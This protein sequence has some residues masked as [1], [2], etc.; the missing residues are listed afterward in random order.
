MQGTRTRTFWR[1]AVGCAVVAML[2][3]TICGAQGPGMPASTQPASEKQQPLPP[4]EHPALFLVGD[5]IMHTG[6]GDGSIGPWGYGAELIP[7]FDA[8]KMHVYNTGL[9]GRSSRGYI[10]E[11]A[12]AKVLER[13]QP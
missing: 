9:G 2:M 12:W 5:S 3:V 8:T 13:L 10:Q 4:T 6:T 7:M 11:G 1:N